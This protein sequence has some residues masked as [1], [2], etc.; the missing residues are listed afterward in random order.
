MLHV[1]YL[2][3]PI[4][5]ARITVDTSAAKSYPGV[6]GVWSAADFGASQAIIPEAW[7]CH[8]T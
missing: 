2:R 4:A 5:H 7:H 3:S 1:A 6:V 8:R